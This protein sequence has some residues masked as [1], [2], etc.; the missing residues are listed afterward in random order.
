MRTVTLIIFIISFFFFP[1]GKAHAQDCGTVNL[2]TSKD[3]PFNKIP[4]LNQGNINI[5]YAYTASQMADYYM[6]RTGSQQRSVHAGWVALN[7]AL[8]KGKR[9]LEIGHT[10]EALESLQKA[11]NCDF[12]SVSG[13]WKGIEPAALKNSSTEALSSLLLPLCPDSTRSSLTLPRAHMYN[14]RNLSDDAAYESF[15]TKRLNENSYPLSIS[16]CSNV[17]QDPEYDGIDLNSANVR[18][19]VRKGC[20]YHESLIV[21]KK[22]IGKNCHFLVRNTWG[23]KWTKANQKLKCVCRH[24]ATGEFNEECDST[25]FASEDFSVEACWI[26]SDSL[27][28]N[29][30]QVTFFE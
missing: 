27:G 21:G 23:P 28:R 11:G 30:G 18:D 17:W 15:V 7:Y 24:K 22:L 26:P 10:K 16:Y 19:H 13:E 5:C 12:E 2:I 9:G 14:F 8:S 20:N 4:V 1:A 25:N 6:I 29:I 3:S